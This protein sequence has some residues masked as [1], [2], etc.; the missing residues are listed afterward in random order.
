[1]HA[2]Q[3]ALLAASVAGV[4]AAVGFVSSGHQA[5]AAEAEE[6]KVPCYGINKCQGMGA[7]H[8]E[9]NGCAGQNSC[10]GHGWLSVEKETCL[11]IQGGRLTPEEPKS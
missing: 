5:Q 4:I 3:Q 10:G 8:G 9:S 1:M 6:Q 11:K 2:K 7:C